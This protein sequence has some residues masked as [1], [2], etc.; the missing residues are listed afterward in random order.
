MP[1]DNKINTFMFSVERAKEAR[2]DVD[3]R[4]D[5]LESRLDNI[6]NKV[7]L[8]D[9]P[10]I[11]MIL[12]ISHDPNDLEALGN[13]LVRVSKIVEPLDILLSKILM[14]SLVCSVTSVVRLP[15]LMIS[16]HF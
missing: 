14:H 6:S 13:A 10:I 11:T 7:R 1:T 12:Q 4:V 15:H 9:M 5:A 2:R 3:L 16:T 8:G